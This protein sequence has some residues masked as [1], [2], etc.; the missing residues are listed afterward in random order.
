[1]P[2][3]FKFDPVSQA[4]LNDFRGLTALM[5]EHYGKRTRLPRV[6]LTTCGGTITPSAAVS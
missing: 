2:V 4:D 5:G 6:A 1:M 3:E